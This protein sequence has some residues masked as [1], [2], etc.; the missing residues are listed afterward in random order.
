MAVLAGDWREA[1]ADA[2]DV[3]DEDCALESELVDGNTRLTVTGVSAHAS[4][5]EKGKNAAK[6]L[7]HVLAK[8]GIGGA[9][10]ALLDEAAGRESAGEDLGIAGSDKVSG[11]LTINLGLLFARGGKIDVTFDCRYPVFF[12]PETIGETVQRR[13]APAGYALEPIEPSVPHHVPESSELVAK[14]MDVYNTITGESAKPFA[15]GGGTYARHLKE[16]VAYGM[17]FPGELELE[18][19]ANESIDVANFV[20]AA[21]IYAYAIVALCA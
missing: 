11:A 3:D 15:I 14:L 17:M 12:N 1:A 8:L 5:P 13:L 7:V 2:F 6:M 19:Q 9:P 20:K 21:R 4:V 18:H 10:I 16:G